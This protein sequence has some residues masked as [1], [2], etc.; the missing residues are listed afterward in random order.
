MG[1]YLGGFVCCHPDPSSRSWYQ[2]GTKGGY[3]GPRSSGW[4][5]IRQYA[6]AGPGPSSSAGPGLGLVPRAAGR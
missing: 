1:C 6:S 3:R 2:P 4:D 5:L